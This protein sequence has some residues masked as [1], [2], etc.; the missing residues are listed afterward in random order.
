MFPRPIGTPGW[1]S[2]PPHSRGH[3]ALAEMP[4]VE[5]RNRTQRR[6][7]GTLSGELSPT[8]A[9]PLESLEPRA[10]RTE[11]DKKFCLSSVGSHPSPLQKVEGMGVVNPKFAIR[12]FFLLPIACCL[13]PEVTSVRRCGRRSPF[14][15][16]ETRRSKCP[17]VSAARS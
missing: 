7:R 16:P 11:Q 3:E 1:Y 10:R 12:N 14:G 13:V 4:Q 2:F 8:A 9:P 17:V 6:L 15:T 5:A